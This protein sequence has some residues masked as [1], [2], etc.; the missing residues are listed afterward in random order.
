M[1]TDF[2]DHADTFTKKEVS[3]MNQI[4]TFGEMLRV[5]RK[6]AG[7]TQTELGMAVGT[8]QI[9]RLEKNE[10]RPD[11]LTVQRMFAP[12]L[13]VSHDPTVMQQFISL[14]GD[15]IHHFTTVP[16]AVRGF[17]PAMVQSS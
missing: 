4:Y 17:T 13:R 12:A 15:H 6:R 5:L 1:Q 7:M 3:N 8:A 14:S 2:L 10:R 9:C 11:P 16:M